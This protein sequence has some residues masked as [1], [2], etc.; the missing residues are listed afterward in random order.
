ML[1]AVPVTSHDVTGRY[2]LRELERELAARGISNALA[3]R[4][5]EIANWRREAGHDRVPPA[6]RHYPTLRSAVRALE[7]EL[8]A[9]IPWTS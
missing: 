7:K 5:T 9:G 6:L 3:G 2:A 8:A 4:Q 1:D